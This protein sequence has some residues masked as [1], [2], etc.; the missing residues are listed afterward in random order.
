MFD[1]LH[2][3]M[4]LVGW[5]LLV[6]LLIPYRRFKAAFAGK[7]SSQ[8]FKYGESDRVPPEVCIPNRNY[9]NLLEV[10]VLFYVVSIAAYVTHQFDQSTIVFAWAY[11]ILRVLHSLVHLTYNKVFHRLS[12][13]AASNVVLVVLWVRLFAALAG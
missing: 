7:V 8:D 6:M 1:I 13:F 2:P 9:M 4:A 5:T 11:V 3:A 10:P 12:L